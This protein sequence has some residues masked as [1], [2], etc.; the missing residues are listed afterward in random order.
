MKN[1]S[2]TAC[3]TG[4]VLAQRVRNYRREVISC[5]EVG[6]DG[7]VERVRTFTVHKQVGEGSYSTVMKVCEWQ[8][9]GRAHIY[10]MKRILYDTN[11]N[12]A[13]RRVA[14]EIDLMRR[15]PPHPNILNLIAFHHVDRT[16]AFLLLEM[17]KGGSVAELIAKREQPLSR[18]QSYRLFLDMAH[19]LNHLHSQDPPI[20]HRDFKLEN[21]LIGAD[22][23]AKLCDFGSA[24]C[25]ARSY[26]GQREIDAAEDEFHRFCTAQ[27]RA[28]EVFDLHRGHVV[29]EK[30]DIWALGTQ[31]P[32]GG[33]ALSPYPHRPPAAGR[34]MP[35]RAG[36]CLFA[37]Q[38]FAFSRWSRGGMPLRPTRRSSAPSTA[39]GTIA[40]TDC[41]TS[42]ASMRRPPRCSTCAS[43]RSRTTALRPASCCSG[44]RRRRSPTVARPSPP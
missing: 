14:G 25:R 21:M 33:V 29:S 28:P 39:P 5:E 34:L 16:G 24:S 30:M 36:A 10:A 41:G 20:A 4:R 32:F 44:C 7:R 1:A 37:V 8:P 31:Y 42:S 2:R 43:S 17:C 23:F 12:E 40:W 26:S 27:Y 38:G 18:P 3:K 13:R 11:D 35:R 19:A 15:L 6:A 22:N 9:D